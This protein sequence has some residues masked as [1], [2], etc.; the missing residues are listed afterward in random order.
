MDIMPFKYSKD[1]KHDSSEQSKKFEGGVYDS[2]ISSGTSS[3]LSGNSLLN[4]V[5]T[6]Q[7][8]VV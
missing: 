6:M 8:Y 1:H 4:N 3:T 7:F 2:S 5:F